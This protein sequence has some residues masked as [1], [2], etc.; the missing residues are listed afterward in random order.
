MIE[1]PFIGELISL[2]ITT[3]IFFKFILC[4]MGSLF[5]FLLVRKFLIYLDLQDY[6]LEIGLLVGAM[7]F[8][9]MWVF[10]FSSLLVS[11]TAILVFY[12]FGTILIPIIFGLMNLLK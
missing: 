11:G 1:I 2:L 4:F 7:T 8:L 6:A 10:F 5:I 9:I 12:F 3:F